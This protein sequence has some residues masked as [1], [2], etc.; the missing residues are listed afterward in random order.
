MTMSRG[1]DD[2]GAGGTPEPQRLHAR[3]MFDG[4]AWQSD[5]TLELRDG[6][7]A[8]V[9]PGAPSTSAGAPGAASVPVLLPGLIDCGVV[10]EGYL[11]GPAESTDPYAPELGFA[12][13]CRA[14]GVTSVVDLGAGLGC[15]SRLLGSDLLNVVSAICRVGATPT[16]RGDLAA[17]PAA[18]AALLR[19]LHLLGAEVVAL[20][21]WPDQAP[22]LVDAPASTVVRHRHTGQVSVPGL[23]VRS[24]E[25]RDFIAPQEVAC[26]LWTVPDMMTAQDA[27]AGRSFLPYLRNYRGGSS[28]MGRRI[29]RDVLTRLYGHRSSEDLGGWPQA[30]FEELPDTAAVEHAVLAASGAGS[31]G[32]LPGGAL[33]DELEAIEGRLGTDV[34]L[35]AATGNAAAAFPALG[36]GRIEPG[37]RADLLVVGQPV[38]SSGAGSSREC[39][40]RT[41]R[42]GLEGSYLGGDYLSATAAWD[43]V[44]ADGASA[45]RRAL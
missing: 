11:D 21:W 2:R 9:L 15:A 17:D 25:G 42:Q 20:G 18:V 44:E 3:R 14:Y 39:S 43:E 27:T 28:F 12:H 4:D 22:D 31:A 10:A 29:A 5:V 33:W 8:G 36:A 32:I 41:L 45:D 23:H 19:G 1:P 7:I 26:G 6:R 24:A 34:A 37:A 38:G 13:L 30:A 35:R 40:I 16:R